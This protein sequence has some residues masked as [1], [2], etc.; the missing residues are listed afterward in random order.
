[1]SKQ[2]L[3]KKKLKEYCP[4]INKLLICQLKTPGTTVKLQSETSIPICSNHV[5]EKTPPMI[6]ISDN[7]LN[8]SISIPNHTNVNALLQQQNINISSDSS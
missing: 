7:P 5:S 4:F 1:M 3:S 2:Y 8:L 6:L